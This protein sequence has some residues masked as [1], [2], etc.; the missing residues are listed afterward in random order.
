M[1]PEQAELTEIGAR[2]LLAHFAGDH[3]PITEVEPL[4]QRLPR[5]AD[6]FTYV[7]IAAATMI[8]QMAEIDLGVALRRVGG[9][10]TRLFPPDL[11]GTDRGAAINLAIAVAGGASPQLRVRDTGRLDLPTMMNATFGLAVDVVRTAA[12]ACEVTPVRLAEAFVDEAKR[13]R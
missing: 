8:A 7:S 13:E 12:Q 6:A 9:S 5:A 10:E 3:P 4:R 2:A 1:T 11:G